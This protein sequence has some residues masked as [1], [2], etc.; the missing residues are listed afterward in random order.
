MRKA[1]EVLH[2]KHQLSCGSNVCAWD[3][4]L[5]VELH[6]TPDTHPKHITGSSCPT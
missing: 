1:V 3:V 2:V 4:M 5:L 6:H